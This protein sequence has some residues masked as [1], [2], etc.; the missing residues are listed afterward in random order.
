MAP[1]FCVGGRAVKEETSS[2]ERIARRDAV[3]LFMTKTTML[4]Y[5]GLTVFA[6]R[7]K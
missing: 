7:K 1:Y 2:V 3:K 6:N 4:M 5:D